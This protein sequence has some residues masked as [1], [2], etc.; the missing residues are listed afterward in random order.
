MLQSVPSLPAGKA[1]LLLALGSAAVDVGHRIRYY[2]AA[3]RS[4]GLLSAV[5]KT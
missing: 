2:S 3:G 1:H 5:G 4:T